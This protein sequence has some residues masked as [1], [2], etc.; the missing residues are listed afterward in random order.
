MKPKEYT[1]R[2]FLK[3]GFSTWNEAIL[4]GAFWYKTKPVSLAAFRRQ[5]ATNWSD[6]DACRI[7]TRLVTTI[8]RK[9]ATFSESSQHLRSRS[10]KAIYCLAGCPG[11]RWGGDHS[12]RHWIW[13]RESGCAVWSGVFGGQSACQRRDGDKRLSTGYHRFRRRRRRGTGS[14]HH[15]VL[16]METRLS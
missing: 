10:S 2:V 13:S 1:F 14:D 9:C 7:I 3:V 16:A 5:P 4:A 12:L 6:R 15:R 8:F 11:H